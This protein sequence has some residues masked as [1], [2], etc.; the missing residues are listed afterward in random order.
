MSAAKKCP[1]CGS[2]ISAGA[3][4][5]LCLKCLGRLGFGA[6]SGGPDA[7]PGT[8]LR[9]GDYKLLEE[10]ARGGMGVV[11]RARQLSLNRLVALKVVLHGPFSSADFVR[12]FH[13]EAQVV[14]ALRHPNIV[15]IYEVGEDR[16][17]HFLA[18]E[19]VEGGS[20]AEL[21]RE[22]PLLVK[23]AANYLK[24]V[25][26]AVEHAHQRGVLHRDLKP[27]N[28]LL[29]GLDQPRVTDFGLAK[30]VNQ[31]AALTVTGQALGSPNYMPPEQAAGKFS[32]CTPQSDVYSLGAILYELLTGRPPFQGETLQAI[33]LQA[34]NAEPVPP[35][36]LN[37]G[38]P[39]DLQ[40]ICLKCLQKEPARRYSSARELAEDLERFLD[41]KPIRARPVA[42]LE[43]AW[44]W[45]RRRPRLAALV[46]GL[47]A[48][49]VL[50]VAG[51]FWQ[52]RLAEGHAQ[53]ELRQRR[54]AE[55]DAAATRLNL[56]AADVAVASQ[57]IQNDNL[58][59]ARRTL[60][61][62]RPQ[63]GETDLRGF[64]WRYLWQLCRGTQ[65][66]ALTGHERTVT[67]SAFSPEG[68]RLVTGGMDGVAKVWDVMEHKCLATLAVTTQ[69]VWSVNFTPDGKYL[70]TGC[71]ESV[72][73][74][75]TTSWRV[76]TNYPGQLA[77]LSK[78]GTFLATTEGSP[79]FW[80]PAGA[81]RLWNWRTGQLLRRLDQ[82]GRAPAL[83]SDGRLLAL[84]G[85]KSGITVWDTATGQR[86]R[87][88]PTKNPIWSLHF[89]PDGQELLSAG[90][91]SEVTLWTLA[92]QPPARTLSGHRLHVW[93]AVFDE[94]GGT[95]A[96][97]S[98]DQ[99]VRLWD[100]A[101]LEP[102][103]V[104]RGHD[105][106]VWCAAFSPDG[107]L[108][109]SGGKDQ[110]VLLWST[111]AAPQADLP[112]DMVRRPTISPDGKWVATIDPASGN[113]KLW[114]VA[115]LALMGQRPAEGRG[116]IGFSRDGKC[117][118][119]LDD[120]PLRLRFWLPDGVI[121]E[122]QTVLEGVPTKK[123]QFAFIG[124]SP[125]RAFFLAIDGTGR[126]HIWN[127]DTGKLVRTI[128]GPAPPLR[129]AALSPRG[130]QIA[131]CVERE[132]VARLYEVDTGTERHLAGH[133]DFVSG[134]AFSPDGATL[135]TGSMD[136]TIGLWN[137]QTGAA[138]ATL[139]GHM[140][141]TTDVA[142]S[143]DGRTLASL[144]QNESLKLWHLPTLREV[145]SENEP[146]AGIWLQF[147]PDGRKLAVEAGIN[148]VRL[149]AA[150][151]E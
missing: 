31:D 99:T 23:R 147:S 49:V 72:A 144:G 102:K 110:Q 80:E 16:G 50:G 103:S 116:I 43:R 1:T 37:P 92:G 131:V 101:T 121:P 120:D 68:R 64:E 146:H 106:E 104:L 141:E 21:A 77:A 9:L 96:T 14:A 132:N 122:R 60:A 111:A 41:G 70:M 65:L 139:P 107:R 53:G 29:D 54:I 83:S 124:M 93:S 3:L 137:T 100:A 119:T 57:A 42:P 32:D 44:L 128:Q 67:C 6:E 25:A 28:I 118:A 151:F 105:S 8:R 86:L 134:L 87:E 135:A 129:N 78:T 114:N 2:A 123:P 97:T 94:A 55:R 76:W 73:F 11:Y 48:A 84:A 133:R 51:V 58:G 46:A 62:L 89:S 22:R 10:I 112:H 75:D 7:D 71:N 26:E 34:Q 24:I 20:F 5:G 115:D 91:S 148:T 39:E 143:P 40:T 59:L 38:T 109:A 52:W 19:L 66:A 95:I 125:E 85:A 47:I 81:V 126:M 98:S 45:C 82:P 79:F 12:R 61:G 108:L 33:L 130:K 127:T 69:A 138:L 88:W 136:G 142:F 13:Q 15:V 117:V 74:W 145:V 17:N 18:L 63:P 30:L 4:D 149:L 113:S 36:R 90:W 56:Y 140:Q 27:S 35:R 150:P